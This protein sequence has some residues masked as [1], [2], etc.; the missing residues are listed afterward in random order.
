MQLPIPETAS[1]AE[2]PTPTERLYQPFESG[3]RA[4]LA[5]GTVGGVLSILH[6]DEGA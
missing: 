6:R 1:V 5:T 4:G 2:K 3:P